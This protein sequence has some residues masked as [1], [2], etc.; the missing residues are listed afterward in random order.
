MVTL[1]Q[2]SRVVSIEIMW[3]S[4][5]KYLLFGSLQKQFSDPRMKLLLSIDALAGSGWLDA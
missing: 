2:E 5:P 3:P 1:Q 4:R